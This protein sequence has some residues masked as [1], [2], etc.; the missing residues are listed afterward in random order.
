[1]NEIKSLGID[2][3]STEH[4]TD[5]V[6]GKDVAR[7]LKDLKNKDSDSLIICIAGWIPSHAVISITEKCL[8]IW[9]IS[10]SMFLM[11]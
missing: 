1:M 3:I 8:M 6:E 7:A 5:D 4:V 9:G 11:L 10:L 2:I